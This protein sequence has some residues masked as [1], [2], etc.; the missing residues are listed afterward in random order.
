MEQ[1]PFRSETFYYFAYGSCMCPVDLK[2]T[3]QEEAYPY[4][5]APATLPHYRLGFY[6][7]SSRRNCGVLD[8]VP[9]A[10]A[11]V[12][13]VL[14][15]LPNR[16]SEV[17]DIR[18]EVPTQGYRREAVSVQCQGKW[19]HGVRTYTVVNKLPQEIPPNEWYF[20]VVLRGATTCGL[21]EDYRWQLFY[22]MYNLRQKYETTD[23]ISQRNEFLGK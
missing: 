15:Q 13:G 19:Y 20:H 11:S 18:E 10:S 6:H 14:Y 16:F 2:R 3:L 8:V 1:F 5:I 7:R 17:L 23:K 21:P 12:I 22:Q 9:D 4:I